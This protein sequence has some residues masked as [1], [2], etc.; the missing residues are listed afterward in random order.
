MFPSPRRTLVQAVI[1]SLLIHAALLTRVVSLFP[2]TLDAPVTTI[3][4]VME[5]GRRADQVKAEAPVAAKPSPEKIKPPVPEPV[6]TVIRE[7]VLAQD[8]PVVRALP[9]A[10]TSVRDAGSPVPPSA[11]TVTSGGGTTTA[12][13]VREGVSADDLRQYRLSLATAARRFK[14]YPALAKERGWEGTVEVALDVYAAKPVPEVG[15]VRSSGRSVLDE[16]A[17]EMMLQA[18]RVTALPEGLNG[19]D[20]RVLLPIQ[21][22]LDGN[23]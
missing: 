13:P 20:F 14:R 9:P 12:A 15:L 6:R 21:F 17:L 8:A 22:S 18:A 3:N 4:V 2:V 7:Q 16:Q 5:R 11:V 23:Q 1:V 19:R 10:Q